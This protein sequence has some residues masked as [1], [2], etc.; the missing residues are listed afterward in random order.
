M[1][2]RFRL[3]LT[4]ALLVV[5]PLG[6]A[7]KFW[8]RGPFDYV[9]VDYGAGALY[10]VFWI[11]VVLWMCPRVSMAKVALGV[12]VVTCV[13]ECMQL[14][15]PL[16]LEAIRAHALGRILI[17]T[18]FSWSDFPFYVAGSGAGY[19]LGRWLASI[20]APRASSSSVL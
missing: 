9:V 3:A 14:W 16:F 1:I 11:L 17:G 6:F 20:S 13:L 12:C 7:A 5:T 4:L 19:A 2:A 18:T 15:H 10:E 8:Y